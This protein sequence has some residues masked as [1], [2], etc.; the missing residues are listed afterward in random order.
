MAFVPP[1]RNENQLDD[2]V[3][4][5]G[6]P[7][8]SSGLFRR[9]N[10]DTGLLVRRLTFSRLAVLYYDKQTFQLAY[11][12]WTARRDLFEFKETERTK[13]VELELDRSTFSSLGCL[14]F[15]ALAY[16]AA[17]CG[18]GG[19]AALLVIF[20]GAIVT[21]AVRPLEIRFR[22]WRYRH[23]LARC[24][25]PESE[26]IYQRP[27]L[28]KGNGFSLEQPPK[29]FLHLAQPEPPQTAQIKEISPLPSKI[30]AS[31]DTLIIP[32]KLRET[33]QA[34]CAILQDHAG[35]VA[36]GVHLPKG[37]LFFGP[38]G[39]GKT[40][41][42]KT[43]STQSGMRFVGLST[44]ECKVGWIGWGAAAI[45]T[46]F[47]EAREKTP[48]LIFIDELDAVCPPRGAYLDC[49]SQEVTAQLLQEIDGLLSDDQ[50]VFLI[51]ATNRVDQID[52]AILSRFAEQIE[53]PLPDEMARRALLYVFLSRMRFEG[54]RARLIV[55][56]AQLTEGQS[57]R[58]LVNW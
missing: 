6:T 31:W 7:P 37:L 39:C 23:L 26:P 57:G 18:G 15:V 48:T 45:R 50:A 43:L 20:L 29:D 38:P 42:A 51:G 49:I 46:A 41:I 13:A 56:L 53:I 27:P 24:I 8:R 55:E 30:I 4:T 9:T 14:G 44:S 16:V 5:L 21:G 17:A 35:Y 10:S 2:L 3:G 54:S 25:F 40:Q 11:A 34:Y 33:L 28:E 19:Q 36:Q 47:A 22:R 12:A 1:E 52:A 58:D 32:P